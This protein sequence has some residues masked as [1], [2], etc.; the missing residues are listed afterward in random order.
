MNFHPKILKMKPTVL[1]KSAAFFY[2]D[3]VMQIC[4]IEMDLKGDKK[5][6]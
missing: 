1:K 6:I 3:F 2:R 4:Y 5:R